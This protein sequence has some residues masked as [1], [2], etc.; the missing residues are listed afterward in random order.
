MGI[1]KCI[2]SKK[3][4]KDNAL[5]ASGLSWCSNTLHCVFPH[6]VTLDKGGCQ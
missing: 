1:N 5:G 4:G 2:Y 6:M 3:K